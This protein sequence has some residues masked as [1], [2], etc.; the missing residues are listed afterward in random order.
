MK[1]FLSGNEAVA[2][3]AVDAGIKAA[4]S[5]PGTPASDIYESIEKIK[6]TEKQD[7]FCEWSVNEK[8]ALETALGVS[9][10]G[11][12]ALCSM[13][14]VGLNV[15]ADPFMNSAYTGANGGLVV[16]VAD[17]PGI[18]SSQN[19]QDSRNYADFA[20]IPCFEP[21]DQQEAYDMVYDAFEFSEK[22]Q[23]PVMIRLVTRVAHTSMPVDR[24]EKKRF[25]KSIEKNRQKWVLLPAISRQRHKDLLERFSAI[26]T[27]M[28]ASKYNTLEIRSSELGVI[29][30]G[31][32]YN[33][34]K[35]YFHDASM[36]KI[37]T[38]P[39]PLEKIRKLAGAVKKIIVVEEGYPFIEERM[40]EKNV[41]GKLSGHIP[42]TGELR[43][44]HM[45][46]IFDNSEKTHHENEK[47]LTPRAPQICVACAYHRFYE[48]L[49]HVKA[50][51]VVG[52]IGCYTLGAG[53]PYNAMDSVV[54]MGAS[55]GMA[56]GLAQTGYNKIIALIGD[57][58]FFHS[59]LTGL[60]DAV[61]NK[62]NITI[63]VLDNNTVAMTGGQTTPARA[64]ENKNEVS[65]EKTIRATGA[66]VTVLRIY[67]KSISIRDILEESFTKGGVK[68]IVAE[69]PC[70]VEKLS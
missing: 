30:A 48:E 34:A 28:E 53:P 67:D 51:A 49:S 23:T 66:D 64:A 47:K 8:V 15:A 26:K 65:L 7:I 60:I 37:G 31:N 39:L 61:H 29:A 13:K 59:G 4:A 12:R 27:F 10:G 33:Y 56:S 40:K 38:Y 32:G 43:P 41:I 16:V 55:I 45:E 44:E 52:D 69:F 62:A 35:E 3:A 22:Y 36:L 58:T 68:V 50:D 1:L 21:S 18:F 9:L 6:S 17:D 11:S 5:Y 54:C 70:I 46:N 57:S 42:E 24:K 14:H 63:V 25:Q 19:E 20:K 2:C